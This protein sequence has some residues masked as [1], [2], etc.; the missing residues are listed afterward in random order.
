METLADTIRE[1]TH[2]HILENNGLVMGQC[3]SAVGRV[4]NTVPDIPSGIVEL[5]LTDVAGAGF[6]VGAALV[7]RRPIFILRFQDFIA[8]N[9][10]PIFNYA[11]KSKELH[12][13][14]APVFIRAIASEGLGPVHSGVFHSIAAHYPGIKVYSPMTPGEYRQVWEEYMLTDDPVFVSE[15]RDSYS[16]TRKMEDRTGYRPDVS[17]FAVSAARFEAEKAVDILDRE[18][19]A[20]NLFHLWRLKPLRMDHIDSLLLSKKGLVI[21]PGYE[22]CGMSQSIAYKLMIETGC[23]VHAMGGADNTKMLNREQR[24]DYP[25][26]EAICGRVREIS[27]GK[28]G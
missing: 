1:I 14:P 24:N 10:S 4:S 28:N 9:G 6:A 3:L 12:G 20:C 27:R 15:H 2:R 17:I 18:G 19:I 23:R 26:A 21:D 7:G 8:L 16:N 13:I 5:P 11:A 22:T 25:D